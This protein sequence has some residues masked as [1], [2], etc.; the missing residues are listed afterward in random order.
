MRFIQ[1]FKCMS[2]L[3]VIPWLKSLQFWTTMTPSNI[4][5]FLSLCWWSSQC[6]QDNHNLSALLHNNGSWIHQ[7][8]IT[9]KIFFKTQQ[10]MLFVDR[11]LRSFSYWSSVMSH[12]YL[13]LREHQTPCQATQEKM[14]PH[15]LRSFQLSTTCLRPMNSNPQH[16][17]LVCRRFPAPVH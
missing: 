13:T 5:I 4:R 7:L 9:F 10:Y 12:I 1:Q 11:H 3:S 17:S 6:W 2:F 15:N 8:S 14:D 16:K